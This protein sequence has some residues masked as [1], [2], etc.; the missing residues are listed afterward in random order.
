LGIEGQTHGPLIVVAGHTDSI[1]NDR[2][3]QQLSLKRAEAVRDWMLGIEG[4]THGP[5]IVV[6][7]H[8]DSIGNDR[9]NQQL[10]L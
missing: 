1:G 8:T 2:S 7:G 5:L 6:A 10:S 3:N 4:Q 9:S